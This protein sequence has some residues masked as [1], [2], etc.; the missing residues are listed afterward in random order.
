MTS[1]RLFSWMT[2]A[3]LAFGMIAGCEQLEGPSGQQWAELPAAEEGAAYVGATDY[4]TPVELVIEGD[5]Y[6]VTVG[7][8]DVSGG[9]VRQNCHPQSRTEKKTETG[10]REML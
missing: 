9:G 8:K 5:T 4:N 3:M 7:G 6:A 10:I 2:A 1:K